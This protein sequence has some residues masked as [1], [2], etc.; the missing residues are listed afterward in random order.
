MLCQHYRPDSN[1]HSVDLLSQV[2]ISM[3]APGPATTGSEWGEGEGSC[4][5]ICLLS[6]H[7]IQLCLL[8]P[9]FVVHSLFKIVLILQHVPCRINS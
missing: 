8:E 2:L 7:L 1:Q 6:V 5:N 9:C 4:D 3:A